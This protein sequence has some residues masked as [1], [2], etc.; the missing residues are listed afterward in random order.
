MFGDF[1]WR[2]LVLALLSIRRSVGY[3]HKKT[4]K[5]KND[6]YLYTSSDLRNSFPIDIARYPIHSG[7]QVGSG[8]NIVQMQVIGGV[9]LQ[10]AGAALGA[11]PE[12]LARSGLLVGREVVQQLLDLVGVLVLPVHAGPRHAVL[13]VEGAL[14]DRVLETG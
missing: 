1:S 11:R 8:N 12:R 3:L 9:K 4:Q 10:R 6:S 14:V 5:K 13:E 7:P 2:G